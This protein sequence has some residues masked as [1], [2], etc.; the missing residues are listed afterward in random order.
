MAAVQR[1]PTPVDIRNRKAFIESMEEELKRVQEHLDRRQWR[2]RN[3]S[4]SMIDPNR[5]SLGQ[6][7]QTRQWN[8]LARSNPASRRRMDEQIMV[9]EEKEFERVSSAQ[10]NVL[11]STTPICSSSCSSNS[12][13]PE[14]E[15]IRV[16]SP[17]LP[18]TGS[19]HHPQNPFLPPVRDIFLRSKSQRSPSHRHQKSYPFAYSSSVPALQPST[20]PY[21]EIP[22]LVKE[23]PFDLM[24]STLQQLPNS[25][26]HSDYEDEE[27][28][29]TVKE[30][31]MPSAFDDLYMEGNG[32]DQQL[33]DKQ[34]L[35][36]EEEQQ[37]E[38]Q[39]LKMGDELHLEVEQKSVLKRKDSDELD[40]GIGK[41]SLAIPEGQKLV[42]DRNTFFEFGRSQRTQ[43]LIIEKGQADQQLVQ[44]L[45]EQLRKKNE[46]VAVQQERM[47]MELKLREERIK[48]LSRQNARLEREKWDLLKKA[49][50]ATERSMNLKT[51]MDL[52]DVQLR[53]STT[54]LDRMNNEL[55][56]VKSAN[57][58]LRL[59]IR[60]LK[61]KI[62]TTNRAAQTEISSSD[63]K[64]DVETQTE[65]VYG[66]HYSDFRVSQDWTDRL[67][68]TSSQFDSRD[69]TPVPHLERHGRER[70]SMKRLLNKF[71]RTRSTVK[72]HSV[73]TL[74]KTS[75][76][77]L[78]NL[79]LSQS[80][81]TSPIT[82]SRSSVSVTSNRIS[83]N[84]IQDTVDPRQVLEEFKTVPFAQWNTRALVAWMEVVVG[85]PQY[86]GT[87]RQHVTSGHA[88][89][90]LNNSD[91]EKRLGIPNP[92]HRR[93]LR[94]TIEEF[95]NHSPGFPHPQ[96]ADINHNWVAY[97]WAIDC[98]L[99][100]LSA[101]LYNCMIDG[102]VLNSLTR[103]DLKK[104]F[105]VS[106]K[107][108]QLS[109]LS[110]VE[111]LRM[112]DYQREAIIMHRQTTTNALYWTNRDVCEWLK[113]I[114]LQVYA[115]NVIATGVHGA[116][117]F[118]ER[119]NFTSE[120][121]ANIAQIPTK[122][123]LR[124]HL[125]TQL[126]KLFSNE[127]ITSIPDEDLEQSQQEPIPP[128]TLSQPLAIP[129]PP[130][131]GSPHPVRHMTLP[132]ATSNPDVSDNESQPIE[133]N[134]RDRMS[135]RESMLRSVIQQERSRSRRPLSKVTSTT[136][137]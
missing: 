114:G 62:H 102:K 131:N 77:S 92:F 24:G 98:G 107:V 109:F 116:L 68:V 34:E 82:L 88:M 54:E 115:D 49:R 110:G 35:E 95:R 51:K 44:T 12:P 15:V 73:T 9:V 31:I 91:L 8:T 134:I 18:S 119:G 23:M 81:L 50:E 55:S 27:N 101:A 113:K 104:Y 16:K 52:Q 7:M 118:L 41:S 120:H 100:H 2:H 43:S 127:E 126:A 83:V 72:H 74:A 1:T 5:R 3:G 57:N 36:E 38:E 4:T 87:V 63:T 58:S 67:S 59:M 45:R 69:V 66:G 56:S 103:D 90:A 61:T 26:I 117:L 70:R 86:I 6:S 78:D 46:E 135:L 28:N 99:P 105:K 60:D 137:V 40:E 65:N 80:S 128:S 133:R 97:T 94:L 20:I 130:N 47:H 121:L 136:T 125:A 42:E 53:S 124:K 14:P 19:L 75:T 123:P 22:L 108:E 25:S 17:F 132:H 93:R 79:Q 13:T 29:D 89:L 85:M 33:V 106:K 111:L 71:R 96:A 11:R 122:S 84:N 30:V 21:D 39:G 64:T 37:E 76:A 32:K 129:P 48:K 10:D 112:H